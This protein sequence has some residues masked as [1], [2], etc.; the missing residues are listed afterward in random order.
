MMAPWYVFLK[1]KDGGFPTGQ[2]GWW[3][4]VL[5]TK[6]R[7]FDLVFMPWLVVTLNATMWTCCVNLIDGFDPYNTE[8]TERWRSAFQ[9]GLSAT[10]GFLLVFRLN[11]SILR[12]WEAKKAWSSMISSIQCLV[13]CVLVH[14][15][16]RPYHRDQVVVWTSALLLS[17]KQTL[18]ENETR[19]DDIS[20][21]LSRQDLNTIDT[22]CHPWLYCANEIRYHLKSLFD[23]VKDMGPLCPV[24][25][26]ENRQHEKLLDMIIKEI[27]MLENI[28]TTPLPLVYVTH[29]RT[30]LMLYLLILPYLTE[31]LWGWWTIPIVSVTAF[32]M[33]GIEGA[34][35][36]VEQPFEKG[37][38]NDL[39][40]D[41][42]CCKALIDI[43]FLVQR[44]ADR[45]A[46][47]TKKEESNIQ[48]N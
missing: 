2:D 43:Q 47:M 23:V 36:E 6:G 22:S 27:G 8:E 16:D 40:L 12:F 31:T 41:Q 46:T 39:D 30:F 44:H 24:R 37:K 13:S 1:G 35:V 38:V 10:L 9:L 29:L 32:L 48:L 11:R 14:G 25:G 28:L 4:T 3:T 5:V 26:G 21:L 15:R 20:D 17:V 45:T 18:R 33:L 42:Y 19:I 7:A 34:S